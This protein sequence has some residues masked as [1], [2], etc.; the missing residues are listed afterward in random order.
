MIVD[1]HTPPIFFFLSPFLQSLELFNIEGFENTIVKPFLAA[2][3]SQMLSRVVL[4]DGN[5]LAD[6][7]KESIVRFKQLRSLELSD[8]V[9]MSDFVLLEVLGTLPSLENLILEANDFESH[10]AH[11]PENSNSQKFPQNGGRSYFEALESHGVS[12]TG[13][14]LIQYLLGFIDSPSLRSI[15]KFSILTAMSL[16]LLHP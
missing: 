2:L 7:L 6:T 16:I 4:R 3:S 9:F 11:A 10:P 8:A 13:S 14:F 12:V 15:N 5:M 1:R